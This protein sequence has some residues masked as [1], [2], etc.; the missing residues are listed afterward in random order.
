MSNNLAPVLA[1][2][3]FNP[4]CTSFCDFW[5]ELGRL[6]IVFMLS[7]KHLKK[8]VNVTVVLTKTLPKLFVLDVLFHLF[9]SVCLVEAVLS[10]PGRLIWYHLCQNVLNEEKDVQGAE[11]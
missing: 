5:Y 2:V 1:Q 3:C 11:S 4:V 6:R 7:L 9:D 10:N 8:D